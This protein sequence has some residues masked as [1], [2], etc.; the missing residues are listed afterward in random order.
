MKL[1]NRSLLD[2]ITINRRMINEEKSSV[3]NILDWTL[4]Q[5]VH[6]SLDVG[7]TPL[8]VAEC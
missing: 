6:K 2:K 7:K 8:N 3:F 1:I 4:K 5:A